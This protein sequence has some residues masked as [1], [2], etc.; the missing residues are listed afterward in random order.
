VSKSKKDDWVALGGGFLV[1]LFFNFVFW[2]EWHNSEQLKR[3]GVVTV[4]TVLSTYRPAFLSRATHKIEYRFK[5]SG[6]L[7]EVTSSQSLDRDLF[8]K[9]ANENRIKIRYL[10]SNPEISDILGNYDDSSGVIFIV[11]L[12]SIFL[13]A[14]FA[15][16]KFRKYE[17]YWYPNR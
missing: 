9:L 16:L 13:L 15:H 11:I 6:R 4:A 12:N 3:N 1:A 17:N 7:K 14:S 8:E 10:P 2:Q 5:L